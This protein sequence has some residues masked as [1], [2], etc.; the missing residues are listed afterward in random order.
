MM[1]QGP[2]STLIKAHQEQGHKQAP[3]HLPEAAL[4]HRRPEADHRRGPVIVGLC[5]ASRDAS[6]VKQPLVSSYHHRLLHIRTYS[7]FFQNMKLC[8]Q[9]ECLRL[10]GTSSFANVQLR[11][12][13]I[14]YD[15]TYREKPSWGIFLQFYKH[16]L[17]KMKKKKHLTSSRNTVTD[18]LSKAEFFKN[19]YTV[20]T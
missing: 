20:A 8:I 17:I 1:T 10:C 9:E 3:P 19:I 16:V 4:T 18:H 2:I 13:C 14:M 5:L 15:Y 6:D 12:G 11:M 7:R